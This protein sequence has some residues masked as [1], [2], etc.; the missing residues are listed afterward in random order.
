M[1]TKPL[2]RNQD[3]FDVAKIKAEAEHRLSR[4]K[5]ENR[6]SVEEYKVEADL[7]KA[8][9]AGAHGIIGRLLGDKDHAPTNVVALCLVLLVVATTT[10][11][12]VDSQHA[13]AMF[14]MTRAVVFAAMGYFAGTRTKSR[15]A[16]A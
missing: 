7:Q 8:I 11:A 12:S 10:L 3:S 16:S 1:T 15:E 2:S 4:G 5:A 9:Q 14:E 6:S 13:N